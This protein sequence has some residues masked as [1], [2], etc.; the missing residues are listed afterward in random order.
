MT[1]VVLPISEYVGKYIE[2]TPPKKWHDYH[3][4]RY[5]RVYA[6]DK[7]HHTVSAMSYFDAFTG[8]EEVTIPQDCIIRVSDKPIGHSAV[9][10]NKMP[11][12]KG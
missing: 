6:V 4:L 5:G 2:Y 9:P 11:N 3:E 10:D 12:L 7:R 1:W 8:Y